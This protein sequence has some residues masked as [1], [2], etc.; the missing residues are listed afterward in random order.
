MSGIKY[1]TISAF[2]PK[3]V[4]LIHLTNLSEKFYYVRLLW[5]KQPFS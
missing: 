1:F 3:N 4:E 5:S 2:Q